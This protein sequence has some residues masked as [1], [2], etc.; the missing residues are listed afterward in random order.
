MYII[1]IWPPQSQPHST[2][3]ILTPDCCVFLHPI[4][5]L[6]QVVGLL[7]FAAL[8]QIPVHFA[9]QRMIKRSRPV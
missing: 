8:A 5:A 1:L 4:G 3:V 6:N 9:H 2:V 7:G